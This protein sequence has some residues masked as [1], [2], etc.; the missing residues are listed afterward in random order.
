MHYPFWDVGIGYGILMAAIAIPHVFVSHFAIGGGLY[1]VVAE[2]AARKTGDAPCL[3]YLERLSRFFVLLTLVFGALTGV[4]IWF[5]IGVLNPAG[6]EVL[7]HTFVWGWAIEW[8]FFVIEI[9]AATLYYYGWR[10][11]TPRDHMLLGWIYFAA[12]WLSLFVINGIITFML[13]PG[14][15]LQTGRFWD[16]FF[17]PTFWP[18]LALRTGICIMLA[19]LFSLLL[20]AREAPGDFKVRLVRHNSAW[21]LAGLVIILASFYWYWKA[22]PAQITS[23]ALRTMPTP[24]HSVQASYWLVALI[25]AFLILFG[26]LLPKRLHPWLAA[27]L[28]ALGFSWFGAYEWFRESVRKPFVVS[29]YMYGNG[30]EVAREAGYRQQGLLQHISYRSAGEGADLFRHACRSCHTLAGYKALKPAFDGTDAAFIA[31]IVKSTHLLRGNMPPFCGSPGEA[32]LIAAHIRSLIDRRHL[33]QI[34]GRQGAELGQKVFS[35]RC[36]RCHE[37]GGGSD[38]TGS[39][40]GLAD[41]DYE[42]MLDMASEL[43]E[44][45]PAF[46]GDAAE[47]AALIQYFRTLDRGGVQ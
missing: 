44:G 20:A 21:G 33:G 27:L 4:G 17:N 41:S 13:T 25:A 16:G 32:D 9:L 34:Y 46:T 40:A 11:M 43:G 12:A 22:I 29:G 14:R 31:A 35:V 30:I 10:R 36:G 23:T 19:G 6:T 5:I 3:A 37:P 18:S 28:M 26:L 8:T 47:R 39:L 7:I 2:R 45:M 42:A 1:L 15:W 38:K 24:I